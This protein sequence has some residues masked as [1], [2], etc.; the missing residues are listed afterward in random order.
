MSASEYGHIAYQ[1][2]TGQQTSSYDFAHGIESTIASAKLDW[3]AAYAT[4]NQAGMDA[5]HARAEAARAAAGMYSGGIDGSQY[6]PIGSGGGS[7]GGGGTPSY[8]GYYPPGGG[9]STPTPTYTISAS[10][11]TGGSISPSGA[12]SVTQGG[13]K[14]FTITANSGYKIKDVLVDG[15]S[16]GAVSTYTFSN[17]TS[18][19]TISA[20][21]ESAASL[22]AGTVTVGDGGSG[23][24]VGNTTKSGYGFTASLTVDSEF[25]TNTTVKATYKFTNSEGTKTVYLEKVGSTWQFPVNSSSPTGARKVYIPLDTPGTASSPK[26]YTITFEVRALDPQATA[27]EGTDVYLTDT[28]TATIRINGS[29]YDDVMSG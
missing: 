14:S 26:T 22:D 17:V 7:G 18:S 4:G 13:S 1:V 8:P 12:V 21:F 27:I 11:A 6:I 9:G 3:W 15:A 24:M 16:V 25:V 10:A 28:V 2:T 19:H 29:M 23:T 5:A 20:V